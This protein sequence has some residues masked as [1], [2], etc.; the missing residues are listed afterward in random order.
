[1]TGVKDMIEEEP[2]EERRDEQPE[3]RN[4]APGGNGVQA[5]GDAQD[6]DRRYH[7][8]GQPTQLKAE[9]P[10]IGLV[11]AEVR[12]CQPAW[13]TDCAQRQGA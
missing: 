4:H 13:Q 10:D 8:P 5:Q 12:H 1:M 6:K 3:P 2:H 9:P 11:P 7:G